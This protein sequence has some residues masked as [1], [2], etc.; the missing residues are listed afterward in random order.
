MCYSYILLEFLLWTVL[1]ISKDLRGEKYS[2]SSDN[3]ICC[4]VGKGEN[5]N[6]RLV[7]LLGGFFYIPNMCTI[8]VIDMSKLSQ[9]EW[10]WGCVWAHLVM[11]GLV[12]EHLRKGWFQGSS[13]LEPWVAGT[14][15]G[16]AQF[17]SGIHGLENHCLLKLSF[18]KCMCIVYIY[19]SV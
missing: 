4:D 14:G 7:P 15:S 2:R 1:Y 19:F 11:E 9:S 10:E 16:Q 17:C 3:I 6:S 5:I 12:M 13:H 18:L 8:R